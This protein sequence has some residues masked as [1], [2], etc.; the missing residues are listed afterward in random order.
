MSYNHASIATRALTHPFVAKAIW[1][2]IAILFGSQGLSEQFH[3]FHQAL[4]SEIC[5]H[6]ANKDINQINS[7]FEQM[8]GIGLDLPDSF[9]A[10]FLLTCLSHDFFFFCSTVS[11]TVTPNNF[12]VNIITQKI[13]SEIDFHSIRQPLQSYISNVE[14]EPVSCH[15]AN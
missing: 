15:S 7:F 4:G 6:S 8:T 3:L 13:L 5:T 9:H 10:M 14:N 2:K 1:N 12:T 11:Q